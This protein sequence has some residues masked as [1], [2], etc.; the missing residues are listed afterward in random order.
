MIVVISITALQYCIDLSI[1]K[2]SKQDSTHV[3]HNRFDDPL[4]F[5]VKL[6]NHCTDKTSCFF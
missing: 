2:E 1:E 4:P 5:A 6:A 3:G